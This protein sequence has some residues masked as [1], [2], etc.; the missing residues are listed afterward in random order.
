[1]SRRSN[2][3]QG[4]EAL[5]LTSVAKLNEVLFGKDKSPFLLTFRMDHCGYCIQALPHFF[6]AAT[7]SSVPFYTVEKGLVNDQIRDAFQ[8]RGYPTT[9]YIDRTHKQWIPYP[10]NAERETHDYIDFAQRALAKTSMHSG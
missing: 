3:K 1:M 10:M 2:K 9:L 7:Q 5:E 6:E 8:V 4:R